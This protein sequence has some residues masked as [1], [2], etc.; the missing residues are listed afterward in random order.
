MFNPRRLQTSTDLAAQQSRAAN[1][2]P[3]YWTPSAGTM[4]P[5][6]P[7][8]G[9][10]GRPQ[11]RCS[12]LSS[13][14]DQLLAAHTFEALVTDCCATVESQIASKGMAVRAGLG[15]AQR[16]KPGLVDKGVRTLLPDFAYALDPFHADYLADGGG[17][18]AEYLL[19][20]EDETVAALLGVTDERVADVHS[21]SVRNGYER[22][23]GRGEREVKASLPAIAATLSRHL[24]ATADDH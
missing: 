1:R 4:F 5:L 12:P 10:R 24:H 16:A 19:S 23:R 6:F 20:R 2:Q 15:V 18:F 22:L 9:R 13:L 17:G 3:W 14:S 11:L 21:R 7:G 8:G